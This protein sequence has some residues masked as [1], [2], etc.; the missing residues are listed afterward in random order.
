[1]NFLRWIQY[2]TQVTKVIDMGSLAGDHEPPSRIDHAYRYRVFLRVP[3]VA[4]ADQRV[5]GIHLEL[6]NSSGEPLL[7]DPAHSDEREDLR[8]LMK[9]A[10][11]EPVSL[12]ALG[13]THELLSSAFWSG[14]LPRGD[15]LG[16]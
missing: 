10:K 3:E 13:E 4:G 15:Y 2:I 1:M 11:C 7:A 14:E 8:E 9:T 16:P 12:K 6:L 5:D